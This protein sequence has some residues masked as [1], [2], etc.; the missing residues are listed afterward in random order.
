M[1][2]VLTNIQEVNNG[3]H[4]NFDTKIWGSLL[5]GAPNLFWHHFQSIGLIICFVRN[6]SK[7][8]P[9]SK[10]KMLIDQSSYNYSFKFGFF[11]QFGNFSI[12]Y[13]TYWIFQGIYSWSVVDKKGTIDIKTSTIPLLV[14]LKSQFNVRI[15]IVDKSRYG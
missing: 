12:S 11:K 1:S 14:I 3:F 13:K 9:R 15:V 10:I 6:T 4:C 5:L 8:I 2:I 7:V